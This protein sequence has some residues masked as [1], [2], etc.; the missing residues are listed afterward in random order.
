MF[1]A[2]V[3]ALDCVLIM[4]GQGEDSFEIFV[5]I[6]ADIIINGHGEPPVRNAVE[7]IVIPLG[8]V[9]LRIFDC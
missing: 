5:A 9:D 2:A 6:Q 1:T 3:G 7:R 4:L 8:I